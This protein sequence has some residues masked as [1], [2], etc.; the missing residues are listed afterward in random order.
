MPRVE[1][2]VPDDTYIK[3]LQFKSQNH[4]K[5]NGK[6]VSALI[7]GFFEANKQIDQ[8]V[9]NLTRVI[10]K[11]TDKIQELEHEIKHLKMKEA[12]K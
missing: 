1:A 8:T 5:T 3:I 9:N 12:L 11:Q 10:Q 6:A 2:Y 4:I 7:K